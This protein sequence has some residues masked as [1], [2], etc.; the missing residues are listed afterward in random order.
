MTSVGDRTKGLKPN[1]DGSLD[2]SIQNQSPGK[3][4]ESKGLPAPP[5]PFRLAFRT[6]Q[7]REAILKGE[8]K[9]PGVQ[10]LD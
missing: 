3:D 8:Y 6:Y 7:P 9:L 4:L 1:H 10:Q 2:I 5:G